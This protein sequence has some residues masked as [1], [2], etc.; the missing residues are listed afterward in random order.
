MLAD[1]PEWVDQVVH[2]VKPS[3]RNAVVANASAQDELLDLVRSAEL[4]TTVPAWRIVEPAP[5]AELLAHYQEA[6]ALTGV[7]WAI[8]AAINLVESRMGRIEGVSTA[9]A[10]GPMQFLPSTWAECCDGDPGDDRDAIIGA[11][12]YLA[13]RGAS[14][15]LDRALLG[16]NNSHHY[17]AAIR[18]YAAVM[19]ENERAYH[20]YHA[21]EVLYL[22][23]AGLLH[24]P[25]GYEEA[26][27]VDASAW[28][29][30]NPELVVLAP[31]ALR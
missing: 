15:D 6:E 10:V 26:E 20:G 29:A 27:P 31:N 14:E 30:A 23:E 17:V 22:S 16:Y 9:G 11:A 21:W 7:P 8:L 28:S 25:V 2:G 3:V 24:L 4:S 13:D 5:A 1:H 12:T 19:E 18:S